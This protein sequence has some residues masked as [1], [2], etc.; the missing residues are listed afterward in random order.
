MC[1]LIKLTYVLNYKMNNLPNDILKIVISYYEID[2]VDKLNIWNKLCKYTNL[3][4]DPY[5][6]EEFVSNMYENIDDI[7]NDYNKRVYNIIVEMITYYLKFSYRYI[8]NNPKMYL[9]HKGLND[10]NFIIKFKR[11]TWRMLYNLYRRMSNNGI[12]SYNSLLIQYI[13]IYKIRC[14]I[15]YDYDDE[16][17]AILTFDYYKHKG[18]YPEE[19]K[20]IFTDLMLK[21]YIN[22]EDLKEI[23]NNIKQSCSEKLFGLKKISKLTGEITEVHGF[24]KIWKYGYSHVLTD[25]F[26]RSF[27]CDVEE[28]DNL[29]LGINDIILQ[30]IALS[31]YGRDYE[32]ISRY[33]E[34]IQC[35]YGYSVKCQKLLKYVDYLLKKL[36]KFNGVYDIENL[37]TKLEVYR[38]NTYKY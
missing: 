17:L 38:N 30:V 23:I 18:F 5:Y 37:D 31:H 22:Y 6:V 16:E 13:S 12:T 20:Y 24:I 19:Y 21:Y 10:E 3:I 4:D 26:L 28:F 8:A 7:L 33:L 15:K 32:Y 34:Y 14:D 11:K 25:V 27:L 2:T 29:I 35:E 36:K 9:K 1:I